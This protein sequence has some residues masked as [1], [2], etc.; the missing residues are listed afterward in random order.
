[1]KRKFCAGAKLLLL[2][3]KA[4]RDE[5]GG[6][7]LLGDNRRL[8]GH[9]AAYQAAACW[10][11]DFVGTAMFIPVYLTICVLGVRRWRSWARDCA[12]GRCYWIFSLT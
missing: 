2:T 7:L 5:G 12:T 1:M 8:G 11:L 6:R 3:M 4:L 10:N 9:A